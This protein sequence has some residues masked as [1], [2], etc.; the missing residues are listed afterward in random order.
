MILQLKI[1]F[2]DICRA[3]INDWDQEA[4]GELKHRF[5]D[6]IEDI[7]DTKTVLVNHCYFTRI[8]DMNDVESVQLHGFGDASSV[9]LVLMFMLEC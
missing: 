3:E 1:L 8:D 5:V 4:D 7:R 2:Q 9:A 6:I